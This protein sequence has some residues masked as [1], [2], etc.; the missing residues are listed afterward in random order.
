MQGQ[1]R[2]GRVITG[3]AVQFPGPDGV[4]LAGHV[5]VPDGPAQ[6]FAVFAHAF[7]FSKD[8]VAPSRIARALTES[9]IAVLRFDFAGLGSSEGEFA[10]T[11][12]SSNIADIDAAANFLR[13]HYEAPS[14][15]IGH[16]LGGAA[17]LGAAHRIPEARAV[18][19]IGAPADPAHVAHLFDESREEIEECG[20]ATVTLAGR[21]F[22]IRR[23]FL[24]DIE[25][26]PQRDRIRGLD[27][28]LLIL[29]SPIDEIVAIDNARQLYDTARHPK[30]FVTIDGANHLLTDRRDASYVASIIAAW[31]SRYTRTEK[32]PAPA[33]PD[34]AAPKGTVTVTEANEGTYAQHIA[35]GKHR[36]RADEPAPIGDD[37]G[38]NPY[39]LL[40]ASLG[41][42]TSMTI[43]MY[44]NRK[45]WPLDGVHVSLRHARVHARDCADSEKTSGYV[46]HIERD[47]RITG[48]LD[49]EQRARLMEIADRC[50]VHRTLHSEI[51]VTT[52]E[53]T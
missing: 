27:A 3:G 48:D 1:S 51:H 14:I 50:P 29:H 15:L 5:D 11:N 42:C 52:R 36:L 38:P 4:T 35:A 53:A 2:E 16:S 33:E 10:D 47:I 28:A 9:G 24:H 20:H 25:S 6:A 21:K 7:T 39:D 31:S 23:E 22:T 26:Q 34:L 8:T 44:A 45:N 13:D 19:T 32:A 46:A 40:L 49:D 18:V 12:F 43:R 17:V 41:A 30:S 37:T